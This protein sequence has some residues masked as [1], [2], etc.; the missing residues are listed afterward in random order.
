MTKQDV[1]GWFKAARV[2]GAGLC[3]ERIALYVSTG[4]QWVSE[5]RADGSGRP[6]KDV[7]KLL[8]QP[9]GGRPAEIWGLFAPHLLGLI[10]GAVREVDSTARLSGAR[11]IAVLCDALNSIDGKEHHADTVARIIRKWR[12]KPWEPRPKIFRV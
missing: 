3:L 7:Q 4:H 2:Q 1:E 5:F 12:K 8:G 10:N 11:Q 6:L 9:R